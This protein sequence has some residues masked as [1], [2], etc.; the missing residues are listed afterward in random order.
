M[1]TTASEEFKWGD[2][3]RENDE[4]GE[5]ERSEEESRVSEFGES[6]RLS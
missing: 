6:V 1:A 3:L 4:C 2:V 5:N